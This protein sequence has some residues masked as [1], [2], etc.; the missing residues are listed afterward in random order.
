MDEYND[1]HAPP[2][3]EPLIQKLI[4]KKRIIAVI[5]TKNLLQKLL[6][7]I[8]RHRLSTTLGTAEKDGRVFIF[9]H[10]KV[11]DRKGVILTLVHELVHV[12]SSKNYNKFFEINKKIYINFFSY[13]Y[14]KYLEA[15]KFDKKIFGKYI[16]A[17]KKQ[18]KTL[19]L[20]P[21][22]YQYIEKAFEKYTSLDR[23]EFEKRLTKML[24]YMDKTYD[25]KNVNHKY[26][27]ISTLLRKTYKK[28]FN[29][30][31]Y[32]TYVG[33]ELFYP[34]EIIS[35]LSSINMKHPNIVKSLKILV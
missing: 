10:D 30:F 1:N 25:Y 11:I 32:R 24:E 8:R 23:K 18:E 5:T 34:S 13:F 4:Q 15:K 2:Q 14:K 3:L 16:I 26:P 7:K 20:T 35:V 22:N 27:E 29:D 17:M 12:A 19:S 33:Q 6:N 31:D 28:L 9:L 21:T